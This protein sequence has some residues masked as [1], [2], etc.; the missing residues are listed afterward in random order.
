[1]NR[2]KIFLIL[3]LLYFSV[4]VVQAQSSLPFWKEVQAFKKQ[5]SLHFPAA[6][7][8][9]FIG[10]S[11]FTM[12]K[13]VQEYFPGYPILNRAFGGS[14]LVDLIL[15]RYEILFPYQPKQVL[16]Y[17]GENDFAASD[18]VTVPTVVNRFKTF[19]GLLRAKYPN[20]P[21]AYVSMKPSPSR[22]HLLEKYVAANAEI[23]SYLASEQQAKF[24]DVYAGMLNSE[25][26]PKPEIFLEDR[27]H[28]NAG[29]YAIWKK[30][31]LPYLTKKRK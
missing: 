2:K 28:M 8:I 6:N 29:G 17:C 5:D 31:M 10:S 27:L 22:V 1:M 15:Y 7:Q 26:N 18:T 3:A 14:T 20:V 9:L 23:K 24:I 13:D 12:W 30:I 16:I 21:V 19:F 25:G 4:P 11:S